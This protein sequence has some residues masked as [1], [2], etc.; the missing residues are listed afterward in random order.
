[1][2]EQDMGETDAE[3]ATE[4]QRLRS[5]FPSASCAAIGCRSR[6][7]DH[8]KRGASRIGSPD[9]ELPAAGSDLGRW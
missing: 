4:A 3:R 5:L 7:P 9:V 6:L 2:A 8:V 1:M